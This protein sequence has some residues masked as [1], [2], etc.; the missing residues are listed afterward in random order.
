MKTYFRPPGKV[1][2]N[3]LNNLELLNIDFANDFAD[4]FDSF[5]E[6]PFGSDADTA[7]NEESYWWNRS[8]FRTVEQYHDFLE[9][10]PE[11]GKVTSILL[12]TKP[13]DSIR[14]PH[15]LFCII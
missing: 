6:D 10:Q 5:D 9:A 13:I 4:N 14:F 11:I 15:S 8:G 12:L 2:L 7:G 3:I 1:P